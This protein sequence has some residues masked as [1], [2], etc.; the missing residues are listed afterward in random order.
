MKHLIEMTT[1]F[2]ILVEV[3]ADSKEEADEKVWYMYNTEQIDPLGSDNIDTN[4]QWKGYA[5]E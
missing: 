1:T 4:T 2:T 5:D 3:E